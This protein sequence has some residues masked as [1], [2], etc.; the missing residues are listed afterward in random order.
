MADATAGGAAIPP[1]LVDSG[2]PAPVF[3]RYLMPAICLRGGRVI[4][5][6]RN[7]DAQADV[8]LRDG[9]VERLG[10]GLEGGGGAG[11]CRP[12]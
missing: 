2:D 11:Q 8:L 6:A 12:G 5:P 10:P 9:W 1:K 4:D 3:H 7:F